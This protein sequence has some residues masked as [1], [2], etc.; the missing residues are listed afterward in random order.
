MFAFTLFDTAVGRCGITWGGRGVLGLQLP[1]KS[2]EAT[3]LRLLRHCPTAEEAEP[4]SG[5]ARA[6]VDIQALLEGEQRSLRAVTLDMSRVPAFNAEVYH[7]AR[8]IPPGQTRTYGDIARVIGQR[9]A[10]RAVGQALGRNPFAIIVPCHRV[11]GADGRM[12]GFSANG[13]VALKL[14]LL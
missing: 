9:S 13:G 11:V 5:V 12:I 1:E 7:A 3:R 10:A 6:I 4:P 14:R 2:H 8:A